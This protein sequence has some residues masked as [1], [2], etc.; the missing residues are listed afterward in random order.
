VRVAK[1]TVVIGI[2]GTTLDSAGRGPQRWERWRPT[3]S[4]AQQEDLLIARLDI[5]YDASSELLLRQVTADVLEVS[6]TTRVVGHPVGFPEPWNFAR[7]YETLHEFARGYTFDLAKYEYLVH[8]TTGSH[9]AQICLFLL[10][11]SRW[12]PGRLLQSSPGKRGEAS[13]VGTHDIIDLNLA[14]YDKLAARDAIAHADGEAFLKS[15]IVT[16][17]AHFNTLMQQIERVSLASKAPLLLLGPTGAGKSQLARR[18]FELKLA[19][20]QLAGAFAEVNCATLRGDQAQSALFGHKRGAFT[21]AVSDRA[22]LLKQADGGLLFLD[23]VG[24]L[25]L[26]EQAFLLRALEDKVFTPLGSDRAVSS[27]FQL[28]CGTNRDL[29]ALVTTGQF[30]EDLLA[31]ISLWTFALPGLAERPED[32]APNLDFELERAART[33]GYRV[34]MSGEARAYY[35][36]FGCSAHATW[37]ANFRDLAASVLRMATLSDGGRITEALVRVETEGLTKRW[38]SGTAVAGMGAVEADAAGRLAAELRRALLPDWPVDLFDEAQL[39]TVLHA[40]GTSSTL[41]AAGRVLFA[42][43]RKHKQS[44][45]DSDRLRKY[46]AR[47]GLEFNQVRA[48]ALRLR[49]GAGS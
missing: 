27:D 10:N 42:E 44:A 5:L 22:G 49:T 21:G 46:L 37:R 9:V 19:R 2:L 40:A 28:L 15:G 14:R 4:L 12:L 47:F 29:S 38:R 1:Q 39:A 3:V 16:Q 8:I 34:T 36:Q 7:V 43:S 17:N 32:L 45:N 13:A 35:L 24:E 6:P 41:A 11:E 33:L 25:G 48:A 30:R 18:I 31:R 20:R 23:E 26:D